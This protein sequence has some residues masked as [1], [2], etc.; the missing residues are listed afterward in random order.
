M[1]KDIKFNVYVKIDSFEEIKVVFSHVF[2]QRLEWFNSKLYFFL[3][4]FLQ[5]YVFLCF[6]FMTLCTPILL[7]P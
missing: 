6:M 2:Y 7:A 1:S 5:L 3:F 4:K